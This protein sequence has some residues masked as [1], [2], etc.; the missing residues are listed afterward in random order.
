[1]H[2]CMYAYIYIYQ[3]IYVYIYTYTCI[4]AYICI[5]THIYFSLSPS[6]PIYVYMY[7]CLY[8]CTHIHVYIYM[9][10]FM[11]VQIYGQT[12]SPNKT[13]LQWKNLILLYGARQAFDG[14]SKAT[15]IPFAEIAVIEFASLMCY[16]SRSS[17]HSQAYMYNINLCIYILIWHFLLCSASQEGLPNQLS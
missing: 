16:L 5:C 11:H 10:I 13:K 9:N 17:S 2:I 12:S 14:L 6:L 1:M 4:C 15:K 7:I 8:I 3:C